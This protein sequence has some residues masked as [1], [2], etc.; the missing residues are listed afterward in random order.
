MPIRNGVCY[1]CFVR[2]PTARLAELE[3]TGEPLT[4]ESCGRMLYVIR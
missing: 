4:C 1:G 3:E 2:F